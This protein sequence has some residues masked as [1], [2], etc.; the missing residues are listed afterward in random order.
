MDSESED[1]PNENTFMTILLLLLAIV[2][3]KIILKIR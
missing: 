1:T 3:I 2:V